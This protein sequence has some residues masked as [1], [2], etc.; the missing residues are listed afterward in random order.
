[1][2]PSDAL[3]QTSRIPRR[4]NIDNRG[5]SLKVDPHAAGVGGK[6]YLDIRL[7]AK[8][9]NQLAAAPRGDSAVKR[10]IADFHLIE[11]VADHGGHFFPLAE[12]HD[13]ALFFDDELMK[14]F[15]KFLHLR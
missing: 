4:L 6:E 7:I 15:L 8:F 12:N 5:S 1:M 10:D 13:F 3:F 2:N 11:K 14:D 9:G